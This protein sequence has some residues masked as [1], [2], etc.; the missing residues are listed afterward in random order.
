MKAEK[1]DCAAQ[2]YV[3]PRPGYCGNTVSSLTRSVLV[4]SV[5]RVN[6]GESSGRLDH[7]NFLLSRKQREKTTIACLPRVYRVS[8]AGIME[9]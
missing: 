5:G 3:V 4:N 8:T 2:G 1:I 7:L 6:A 9:G